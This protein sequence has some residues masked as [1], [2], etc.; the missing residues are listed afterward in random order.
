MRAGGMGVS[1]SLS[2]EEVCA[3]QAHTLH[4]PGLPRPHFLQ[5]RAHG[6]N[7]P[8]PTLH[9]SHVLVTELGFRSYGSHADHFRQLGAG[10]AA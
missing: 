1:R 7:G 10:G 8:W 5:N 2:L 9:V 3:H 6:V 4:T